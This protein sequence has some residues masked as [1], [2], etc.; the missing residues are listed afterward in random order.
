MFAWD[1]SLTWAVTSSFGRMS[2][3]VDTADG[4]PVGLG[5]TAG[6]WGSK[7]FTAIGLPSVSSKARQTSPI[8]PRPM[9][10]RSRYRA[11]HQ[12]L[13]FILMPRDVLIAASH[14]SPWGADQGVGCR[15]GPSVPALQP[16]LSG[17][18]RAQLLRAALP[19]MRMRTWLA[20]ES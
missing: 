13:F 11:R 3:A 16:R 10:S 9:V 7:S 17:R 14:D 5:F 4:W 2:P 15:S 6:S 19:G 1:P 8:A 20:D 12:H 18:R